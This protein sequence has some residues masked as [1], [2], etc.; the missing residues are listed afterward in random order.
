MNERTKEDSCEQDGRRDEN[1][2]LRYVI[3]LTITSQ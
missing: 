3:K 1:I 2:Y